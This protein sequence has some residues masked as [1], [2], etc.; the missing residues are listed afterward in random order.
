MVG[1]GLSADAV[2]VVAASYQPEFIWLP[3]TREA[4]WPQARVIESLHGYSLLALPSAQQAGALH[5]DLALMLSTS[6]STGSSKYVRLTR[7]NIWANAASIASYLGLTADE[8]PI[9]TLPPN[10]S[11]GLS[12]L[13]SHV[14]VGAGLAVTSKGFF[15]RGFWSFLR[16]VQATS[17]AG[18]PYHY[19]MLKKLRFTKMELP[20]LRTLTQAGGRM[21]PELTREFAAHCSSRGMRFFTMYGQ[22]EAA[23]RMSYVP[24]AQALEKAGS[25]GVPVPNGSFELLGEYGEP[26]SA[27]NTTG[28]LVYRGQNVCM[29]YAES[30]VDLLLGDENQGILHTGDL[31]Q[32]DEDG[33][34]YIVGRKK[35][36]IK[37][38]G[39]RINLQEIE[40]HLAALGQV[41]ACSGFDD[42]LQVYVESDSVDHAHLLKKSLI[43]LLQ[44]AAQGLAVYGV[45]ALPRSDAGK[46]CYAELQPDKAN[47]LA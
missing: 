35:R 30:R 22:T 38:F 29:G 33:Y 44:V 13:H 27:P 10:Y 3:T 31:A 11:Y 47:L 39:N 14:W 12:V 2:Q 37:L 23:P 9:T 4:E 34:Y 40:Q 20:S 45:A 24:A 7:R 17:M 6:G 43:A 46:I 36:F 18:V 5:P 25:A 16:N 41:A 26:I 28:E 8:L 21:A 19:E 32:R 1:A 42:E 15:D